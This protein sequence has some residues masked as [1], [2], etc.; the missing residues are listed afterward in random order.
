MRYKQEP[1]A[2]AGGFFL[3]KLFENGKEI[4]SVRLGNEAGAPQQSRHP[5]RHAP[6]VLPNAFKNAIEK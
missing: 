2:V 1:L 4:S 6:D 5:S 3:R